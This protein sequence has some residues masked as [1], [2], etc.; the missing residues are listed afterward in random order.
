MSADG[1]TGIGGVFFR[2]RDP[3]ALREWYRDRLGVPLTEHGH[4][5]FEWKEPGSSVWAIFDDD[6]TYFGEPGAR[7]MV[8]FRVRDLDALLERLRSEGVEVVGERHDDENGRFG[9]IVD[10]EGNRVELWQPAQGS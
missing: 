2:A 1:V 5:V 9:W 8:N 7:F 3:R 10:P 4:A 6:T